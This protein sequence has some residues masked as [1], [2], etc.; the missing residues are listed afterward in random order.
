MADEDESLRPDRP[1]Q[2]RESIGV[3][4]VGRE[5]LQPPESRV[6]REGD[7]ERGAVQVI[8]SGP[9]QIERGG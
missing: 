8:L 5:D 9:P 2:P 4:S 3:R 6:Q 1:V 7:V